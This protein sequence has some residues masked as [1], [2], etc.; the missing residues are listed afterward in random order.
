MGAFDAALQTVGTTLVSLLLISASGFVLARRNILGDQAIQSI[1]TL[2]VV[3]ILP[4][5]ILIALLEGMSP[6]RLRDCA[7][8]VLI[9][10]MM[11]LIGVGIGWVATRLWRGP[12][13]EDRTI[14]AMAGMQN[15]VYLPLPLALAIV[16]EEMKTL[17]TLY[18]AG[19]FMAMSSTQWTL[20][21]WL[22]R[23]RTDVADGLSWHQRLLGLVNPPIVT[24]FV[25]IALSQ[26]PGLRELAT[27]EVHYA[28]LTLVLDAVRKTGSALEP[29]A[30]LILGLMIGRCRVR[31]RLSPRALVIPMLVRQFLAPAAFIALIH[32]PVLGWASPLLALV[33]VIEA[34]AP[35][36]TNLT[37]VARRVGGDWELISA[38]LL[39][40]YLAS[41][42]TMPFWV[43]LILAARPL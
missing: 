36:A 2:V 28:P 14:W 3:L 24:I 26:I 12:T 23:E 7:L 33:M 32:T 42:L 25:G 22:L 4:A 20:G 18:I 34:A 29:L 37:I 35:S 13:S 27:G 39:V 11:N 30:M 43:A 38:V 40:A 17:A 10:V 5:R 15:G 19:A 8:L 21:V 9:M 31:H 41:V 1:T 6:E 16:P